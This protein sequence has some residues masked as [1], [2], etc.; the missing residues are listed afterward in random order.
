MAGLADLE[1]L[2]DSVRASGADVSIEIRGVPH[3]VDKSIDH[4]AFR[5]IQEGLTN[6]AKHAG[7]AARTV[8]CIDWDPHRLTVSVE[9]EG[10]GSGPLPE[11][12]LHQGVGL[13]GLSERV[14]ILGGTFAAE[15]GSDGG[16]RL[17]ARFPTDHRPGGGRLVP[18]DGAAGSAVPA[19]PTQAGRGTES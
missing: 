8:V 2:L 12:A 3:R 14:A 11:H 1:G 5:L 19:E 9:D 18:P 16:F 15:P 17:A 4:A 10:G 13:A 7:P 6:V